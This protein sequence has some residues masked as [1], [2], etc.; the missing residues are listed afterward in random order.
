[1]NIIILGGGNVGEKLA[2]QLTRSK[3]QVTLFEKD[4]SLARRLAAELDATVLNADGTE[5]PN[6]LDAKIG[7]ADVFIAVTGDDKTNLFACQLATKL[8][9]RKVMSRVNDPEDLEFF[10]DMGI[11]A[12]N[13]T[14]VTV[15]AIEES[16]RHEG[17][18]PQIASIAD[19][20]GRIIRLLLIEESPALGHKVSELPIAK[21]I[22]AVSRGERLV[23]GDEASV[24][25]EGDVLYAVVRNDA[26]IKQAR[27]LIGA[28]D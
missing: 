7:E 6:L 5:R 2:K 23:F 20:K 21:N 9:A 11:T 4:A 18:M 14:L 10:L 22:F 25:R 16:V 27:E 28:K 26:E 24:L 15:A 17:K 1:M 3:Y 8:G 13:T 12:I 19:D